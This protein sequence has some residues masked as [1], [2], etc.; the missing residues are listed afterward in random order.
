MN[1]AEKQTTSAAQEADFRK[2]YSWLIRC[3]E[4]APS[5]ST[6][7]GHEYTRTILSY[8]KTKVMEIP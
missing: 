8:L 6:D 2:I 4:T 1:E 7:Q 5:L 3:V